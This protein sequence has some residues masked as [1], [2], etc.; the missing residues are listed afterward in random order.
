MSVDHTEVFKI[1]KADDE[2]IADMKLCDEKLPSVLFGDTLAKGVYASC[3]AG[4]ILGKFGS[5]EYLRRKSY[6]S[7]L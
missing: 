3:Y 6:W 4:W 1:A 5:R 7:T 2:F